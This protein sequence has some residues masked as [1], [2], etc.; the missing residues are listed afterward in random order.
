MVWCVAC[1]E[2]KMN[3]HNT[4]LG[5]SERTDRLGDPAFDR[6]VVLKLVSKT[7]GVRVIHLAQNGIKK[8]S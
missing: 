8:K 1:I 4:L 6:K 5:Y 3:I 7:W 2:A